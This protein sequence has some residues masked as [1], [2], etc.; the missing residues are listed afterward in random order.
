MC[1]HHGHYAHLPVHS[2]HHSHAHSHTASSHGHNHTHTEE[3]RTS[4][5]DFLRV[6]MGTAL[7]GASVL[8]LAGHRAA[9]ANAA[10]PVMDAKLFD[11]QKV[12]EGVFLAQ[13]RPQAE[14]NCNATIFVRSKDVVVVDAHS[15][16]SA[17]AALISQLRREVTTKPVR[18]VIDTHFHWDHTQGDHAYRATGNTIDFISTTTTSRLLADLA[19]ARAQAALDEV[20]QQIEAL[21]KEAEKATSAKEKAYCADQI[22]QLEAFATELKNYSP[23]LPTITF[24]KSYQLRDPAFD[25]HLEFLGHAHT[26]GDLFVHCPQQRAIATGDAGIG[27]APFIADGFP[28]AWPRTLAE[29]TKID[30]KYALPGHG[31]PQSGDGVLRNLS[32]YIK[33]LTG[34][35]ERGKEAGQSIAEMQKQITV[36]SLKSLASNG[37]GTYLAAAMAAGEPHFGPHAPLQDSVNTNIGEIYKN[38]DRV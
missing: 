9:W 12:G 24:D 7:A 23:E 13:A 22:R 34:R 31:A 30:F 4:R 26:A 15:K 38:L 18:Y 20:P 3:L 8:E 25:L 32:N 37:Y 1:E 19:Q 6:L 27:W 35:V 36:A 17:A 2:H 16:P 21:R 5:R 33:E 14:V 11:L 29:V 28:K 10:A